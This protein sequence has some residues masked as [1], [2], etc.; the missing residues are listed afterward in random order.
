MINLCLKP[1]YHL[2]LVIYVI[3]QIHLNIA[4]IFPI[5]YIGTYIMVKYISIYFT[6]TVDAVSE[7]IMNYYK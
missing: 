7:C 3:R 4:V 2:S 5:F 1:T 6:L